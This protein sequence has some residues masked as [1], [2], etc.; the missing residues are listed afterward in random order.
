ME[1]GSPINLPTGENCPGIVC[2]GEQRQSSMRARSANAIDFRQQTVTGE[3]HSGI[4][5]DFE[6]V[7]GPRS[8]RV[9][10]C[11]SFRHFWK[12]VAQLT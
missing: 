1:D 7:P 6:T 5:A 11:F 12:T 9:A 8:S 3:M 4:L 2:D 10:F